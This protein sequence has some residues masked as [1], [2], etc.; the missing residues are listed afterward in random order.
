MINFELVPYNMEASKQSKSDE[1]SQSHVKSHAI[2]LLFIILMFFYFSIIS[3]SRQK[4]A[5]VG[6]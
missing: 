3:F 2:S 6:Q 5:Y 1:F 4:W